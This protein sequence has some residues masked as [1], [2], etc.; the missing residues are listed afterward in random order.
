MPPQK[1]DQTQSLFKRA[2]AVMPW[3][4]SSNFRYW[5]EETTPV[6]T[7]AK[8]AYI[9]DA[10]GNR[11]IDYRLAFG[12]IILGHVDA[13]VNQ[14]VT[15]AIANGTI[16]AHTHP[17]EIDV[18]ERIVGQ[19]LREVADE[20][21]IAPLVAVGALRRLRLVSVEACRLDSQLVG[22]ASSLLQRIPPSMVVVVVAIVPVVV[23]V[24]SH[25]RAG[26][27][28]RARGDRGKAAYLGQEFPPTVC[29]L[30]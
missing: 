7:R 2:Q 14:A 22:L 26:G 3:G 28:R 11:Y 9:W 21:R 6:I 23:A 18:A 27:E 19:R 30:L 15:D 29:R 5:G 16:Y 8:G 1:F 10:D 4:V 17:L 20:V 25:R 24:R 13:R 12:P